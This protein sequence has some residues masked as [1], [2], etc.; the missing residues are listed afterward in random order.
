MDQRE[1]SVLD[2]VFMF[3][4]TFLK[5]DLVGNMSTPRYNHAASVVDVKDIQNDL[6]VWG[7]DIL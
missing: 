3:N 5:W 4:Q 1:D 2:A 6:V 7:C